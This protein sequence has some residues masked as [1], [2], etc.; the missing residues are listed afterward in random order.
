MPKQCYVPDFTWLAGVLLTLLI[1]SHAAA[2]FPKTSG[3]PDGVKN[4]QKP[5]DEPLS[6]QAALEKMTLPPGFKATLFAAEPHVAQPIAM[7][8][9]DRG[10]LWVLENYS[11]PI[12]QETG[13]DRILIFE[14]KDNDGVFDSRKIFWDKGNY[15][16]GLAFGHGG[17]WVCNTPDLIFIPDADGDDVPDGPPVKHLDGWS[18][19]TRANVI[20]NLNWGPDGWLYGCIGNANPSRVGKPGTPDE[21]RTV[22]SRGVWRYHPTEKKFEIVS[23]GGVNPWGLDFNDMGQAFFVNCVLEHLWHLLPGALYKRRPNEVDN[24]YA[25]GRIGPTC[26]HIHWAGGKWQSSRGGKGEH[27]VR[28]GG[29]AHTGLMIYQGNNWPKQYRH[30]LFMNNIH[31]HRI[32]NDVLERRGSGYVGKHA[33]DFLRANDVWFRSLSMKYG[34]DGGVMMIDWQD[35]GECHDNDGVHRTSGRIYK[36][37]FGQKPSLPAFDLAKL[38]S[39]ELVHL[40]FAGS[41]WHVRHARRI[42]HERAV[43]GENMTHTAGTLKNAFAAHPDISRKLRILWALNA[44]NGLDEKYLLELTAHKNEHVRSWA[45]RFLCDLAPP[46]AQ[47]RQRFVE[48][49]GSDGSALVRVYLAA[50][51]QRMPLEARWPLATALAAREE[52]ASDQ[53]IPLMIWYGVE[54]AVAASPAQAV[55]FLGQSKIPLLRTFTARRI[56]EK[57]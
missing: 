5:G 45:V 31:G 25:Y 8:F 11:Y 6:P 39:D 47:A 36:I 55:K 35:Y 13:R 1:A 19:K 26:D 27:D 2:E 56:A 20:N 34:P 14:D 32:N 16:T 4:T 21:E 46:S 30:T 9:D 12:W 37:T 41:E 44:V 51:L 15:S 54:P 42:L 10:R 43:A 28:G 48:M 23:Q 33:P 57:R 24:P 49:A 29:H 50:M 52:D 40:T 22:I 53:N 17:V 38:R 3:L 18:M 7:T